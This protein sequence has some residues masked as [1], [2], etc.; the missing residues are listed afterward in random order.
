MAF[1][2]FARYIRTGDEIRH[3]HGFRGTVTTVHYTPASET[4]GRPWGTVSGWMT[5]PDR[6]G[7][8][9]GWSYPA[10]TLILVRR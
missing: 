2:A 1:P 6:P 10:E 3:P 9:Q 8:V 7:S 5:N 4:P